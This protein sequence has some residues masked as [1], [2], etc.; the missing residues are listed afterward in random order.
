M[1]SN[2]EQIAK[3]MLIISA[4]ILLVIAISFGGNPSHFIPELYHTNSVSDINSIA[5]YRSVMGLI[6]GCCAFW[7]YA[8]FHKPFRLAALYSLLFAMFGL[9]LS[10]IFSL[11]IDGQPTTILVVYLVMEALTGL[12][13][14]GIIKK[15][16]QI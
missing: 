13:V 1:K 3:S 5:I 12:T 11:I 2:V 6:L 15:Y 7:L 14:L 4:V 10:R 16:K 9:A 8:A